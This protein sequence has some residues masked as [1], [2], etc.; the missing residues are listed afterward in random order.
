MPASKS[1][2]A[3]ASRKVLDLPRISHLAHVS[4][5]VVFAMGVG[6][7]CAETPSVV[8]DIAPIHSIVASVMQGLAEPA[9]IIPPGASPHGY[10]LRPSEAS[11]LARADL[12][13]W[14]GPGLTPWLEQPLEAL[15]VDARHLTLAD[16]PGI[17]L[18]PI[19]QGGPFE[20]HDHYEADRGSGHVREEHAERTHEDGA[21][22]S[23]HVDPHIWLDPG[24]AAVIANAV[25]A[26]LAELDPENAQVYSENAE[27]FR[28]KV[29]DLKASVAERLKPISETPFF[30]FH[31]GYQY[32]E[33]AFGL[34]AAGS[35][36]MNDAQAPGAARVAE[37]RNRLEQEQV[38]C[39]F[40]EPQF[41]PKLTSTLTD[42]TGV[43]TGILDPIGAKLTSGSSL[44]PLL[45][46]AL[47]DDLLS[48]IDPD[49]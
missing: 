45:I 24:N 48:C 38:V 11:A 9:L 6:A 27:A 44:Y 23:G 43:R 49:A 2:E 18:L 20:A 32:F 22:H 29:G 12:V 14:V 39:I 10:A 19:R 33:Y 1:I 17:A 34:P 8:A 36:T 28:T 35:V 25:A 31:D 16:A 47:A 21:E 41:E 40:N 13:V 15:A 30:V 42:G 7:A 5:V 37:I 26:A 3:L 4:P 46:A